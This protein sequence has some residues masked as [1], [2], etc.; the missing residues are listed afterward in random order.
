M[1]LGAFSIT[2]SVKDIAL[3]KPSMKSSALFNLAAI[4]TRNG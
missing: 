4:R 1:K 2:L 3:S